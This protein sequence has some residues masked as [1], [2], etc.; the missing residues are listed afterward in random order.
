MVVAKT[1]KENLNEQLKTNDFVNIPASEADYFSV[2]FDI[3][4]KIE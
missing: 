1:L 3:P 2:A 4:L